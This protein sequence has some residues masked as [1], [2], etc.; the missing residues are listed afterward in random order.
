[1]S[2]P[3]P[4]L[5]DLFLEIEHALP[6]GGDWCDLDKAHTLAAMIVALRP[7]VV[8][9]I[10]VWMGGSLVPILMALKHA[11][12]GKAIGI[13]P[14]AWTASVAD[15]EDQANAAWW[16][17]VDHEAAY[18]AFRR[19]LEVHELEA[20]CEVWRMR[21]DEAAP[22]RRIDLLHIDGNHNEQ[23]VRDV[24]RFAP[25]VPAGGILVMDDLHWHG[26][27]VGK[28]HGIAIAMGFEELYALGTGAVL[29]RR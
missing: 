20:I 1:M 28:A 13:D 23:A 6:A 7:R 21:S 25:H 24:E 10:G 5:T 3:K 22:P 11:G 27:H 16:R 9:E 26:G 8:L 18:L 19:R 12:S 17:T 4:A 15:E 29:Q 2:E 14:W